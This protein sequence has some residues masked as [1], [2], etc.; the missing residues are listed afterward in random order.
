MDMEV[1]KHSK[2]SCFPFPPDPCPSVFLQGNKEGKNTFYGA[3]FLLDLHKNIAP[4]FLELHH[5]EFVKH[6]KDD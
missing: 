1:L 3:M 2:A 5:K 6:G 4:F